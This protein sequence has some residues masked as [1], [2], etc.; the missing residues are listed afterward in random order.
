[1]R[2]APANHLVDPPPRTPATSPR[3]MFDAR[4]AR[5]CSA[6]RVDSAEEAEDLSAAAGS[7]HRREL[8][9]RFGHAPVGHRFGHGSDGPEEGE[10]DPGGDDVDTWECECLEEFS[11]ACPGMGEQCA[12]LFFC[13]SNY[14]SPRWKD[15]EGDCCSF[16]QYYNRARRAGEI[17][18][19]R[20]RQLAA[21]GAAHEDEELDEV[22]DFFSG[23][24]TWVRRQAE[25]ERSNARELGKCS[26]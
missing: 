3:A 11:A 26:Q 22:V 1:M 4:G 5:R 19:D 9:H 14:V 18:C 21:P 20:R 17:S 16:D 7:V 2:A 12:A 25:A 15:D 24:E 6:L 10:Y 8:G 23:D 13:N